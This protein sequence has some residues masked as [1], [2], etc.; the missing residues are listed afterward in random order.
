MD[1]VFTALLV[2][3]SVETAN[4][5]SLTEVGTVRTEGGAGFEHFEIGGKPFLASANFWDGV[6]GG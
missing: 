1:F 6:S 3:L 4:S 5:L 2:L